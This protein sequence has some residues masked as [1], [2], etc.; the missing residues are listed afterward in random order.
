MKKIIG[1]LIILIFLSC[2][3]G[4]EIN[5]DCVLKHTTEM[6]KM[7]SSAG[8]TEKAFV[9][10]SWIWVLR[11]P[12]G[13]GVIVER[14]IDTDFDSIGYVSPIE[15][16]MTFTDA[17]VLL[18]SGIGV[19][20]RLGLLDDGNIDYFD[21]TNFNIPE[22]QHFWQ[23]DTEF[24]NIPDDSLEIIFSKLQEY[25]TTDVAIYKMSASNID[26]LLNTPIEEILD[27]LTDTI[28]NI[29]ITDTLVKIDASNIEPTSIY[30]IKISSSAISTLDYITDTSIGLRAFIRL[31]SSKRR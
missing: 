1:A 15:S 29:T 27:V 25:D 30:M 21:T 4:I 18:E 22:S 8:D 31:P 24:I 6:V 14:K 3:T 13:D 19:S 28:I 17:S 23:P 10:L 7:E 2:D 9:N 11:M 16:L 20:Y 12:A 26:S 5:L